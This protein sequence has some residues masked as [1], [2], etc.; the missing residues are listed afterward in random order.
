MLSTAWR[1]GGA[2]W[3]AGSVMLLAVVIE[4]WVASRDG[5]LTLAEAVRGGLSVRQVRHRVR[6]GEW[7][8]LYPGVYLADR[9][10]PDQVV[11]VRAAVAWAGA[12]A[13][14]SGLSAAWWWGLRG[15]APGAVEVSVPRRRS[16][17]CPPGVLLRRRDLD[18]ADLVVLRGLAVTAL[19]TG[20]PTT[21]T[22]KTRWY[23]QG[24]PC[25]AS[26]G[27]T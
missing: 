8:K 9:R 14:A 27:T 26:P 17:R 16:P 18:P 25:C 23:S 10:D 3:R 13:V 22:G 12:D 2:G 6:S 24:G 5:V 21:A 19:P 20:S 4:R 7:V 1:A 15:W 11:S